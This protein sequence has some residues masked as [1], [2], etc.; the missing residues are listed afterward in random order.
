MATVLKH[1]AED[2]RA[3]SVVDAEAIAAGFDRYFSV[4]LATSA[5]LRDEV[6]RIRYEVYCEEFRY[7]PRENFPDGRERDEYD[8]GSLHCLAFHRASGRAAGC[9]RLV[10]TDRAQPR[11]PLPLEKNCGHSLNG[12]ALK[13]LGNLERSGMCEISRLAVAKDFR[14]RA[15]EHASRYGRLPQPRFD[16]REKRIFPYIATS[17]YLA[18]TALTELTDRTNVIAM[19]EPFLPRMMSRVGI[20]FHPIGKTIEYHGQRA[21]YFITT[22]SA[23]RNMKTELRDLYE[24]IR[25]GLSREI[26]SRNI[27]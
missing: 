18:A 15:G 2:S 1:N 27:S 13:M 7:E 6:Y 19:M 11:A 25:D 16:P 10:P 14:R 5:A 24:I 17:M 23:L 9:V 4:K 21:P 20:V 8:S 12:D 22:G 3:R 26:F